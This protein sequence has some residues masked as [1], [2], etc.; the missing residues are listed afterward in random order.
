MAFDTTVLTEIVTI[1]AALSVA[2]E[3]LV[4]IV[5]SYIPNL[6]KALEDEKLEAKRQANIQVISIISGTVTAALATAALPNDLFISHA[7]DA[8]PWIQIIGLGLLASG[9]SGLWNSVLSYLVSVKDIK[10]AVAKSD[11]KAAGMLNP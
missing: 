4:E 11:K 10:A 7:S 1:V 5:K 2:S 8:V 3:R 9:G 6:N